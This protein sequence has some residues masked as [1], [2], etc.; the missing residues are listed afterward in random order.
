MR[1]PRYGHVQADDPFFSSED[2]GIF[3]SQKASSKVYDGERQRVRDKLL[4]LHDVLYP[5]IRRR[6]WDLHPHWHPPNI[7]STWFIG[8]I[9]TIQFMKLRYLRSGDDVRRVGAMMGIPRPLDRAETQY[10]KHPMIGIRIDRHYVALELLLTD[11]AWW[12]AQNFRRKVEQH[13]AERRQFV[14][15][16]RR[17]EADSIFGGWPDSQEPELITTAADLADEGQ[18]LAWLAGFEPGYDWLRL[19]IWYNDH[20]NPCLTT[21]R[22]SDEIIT[23][24][25][26]LYPVYEFLLWRPD[27]NYR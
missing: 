4:A 21:R 23:H 9:Q 13:E 17:L 26:Q 15:L 16:L 10:T 25:E 7:V 22:I 24:F 2:Y 8:R 27:N 11:Q 12:D 14:D 1:A 5:E 19:G 6:G 3:G 20:N 18:L